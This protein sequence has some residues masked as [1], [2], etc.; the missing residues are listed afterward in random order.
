MNVSSIHQIEFSLCE[1][2]ALLIGGRS[3]FSRYAE[4]F[5]NVG[6]SFNF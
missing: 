5:A 4:Q 3:D 6:T 1:Y 2:N